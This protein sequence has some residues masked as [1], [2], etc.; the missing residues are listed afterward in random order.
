MRLLVV[1]LCCWSCASFAF[2]GGLIG[3]PAN[4]N[5]WSRFKVTGAMAVNGRTISNDSGLIQ[6]SAKD[7]VERDQV[8]YR[9]LTT[10]IN[11]KHGGQPVSR[12]ASVLIRE[13][14]CRPEADP[15]SNIL[16]LTLAPEKRYLFK[17]GDVSTAKAQKIINDSGLRTWFHEMPPNPESLGTKTLTVSSGRTL[18]CDGFR[19][20]LKTSDISGRA[21]ITV[22][23]LWVNPSVPFGVV[24]FSF[25]R[26]LLVNDIYGRPANDFGTVIT[27]KYSLI[28]YSDDA[29]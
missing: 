9:W 22:C 2:A 28:D 3:Q 10:E 13:S 20:S 11:G 23:D 15:L 18:N 16:E 25:E 4:E 24:D 27:Q 17:D 14:D 6:I 7:A 12:V 21:A 19:Y 5:A 29:E 26:T 1:S 8:R